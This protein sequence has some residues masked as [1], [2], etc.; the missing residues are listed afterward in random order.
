[1]ATLDVPD[2][3]VDVCAVDF[4]AAFFDFG[5]GFELSFLD[6]D[7]VF[8]LASATVLDAVTLF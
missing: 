3:D 1:M 8:V 6:F 5:A 2:D 4:V 7:F